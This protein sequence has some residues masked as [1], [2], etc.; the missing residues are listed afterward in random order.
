MAYGFG[1]S[2]KIFLGIGFILIAAALFVFLRAKAPVPVLNSDIRVSAPVSGALVTSPLSITG[3]ARGTWFFEA[4]FPIELFDAN[5][6]EILSADKNSVAAFVAH[7]EGEWMT[8]DFVPFSATLDFTP[9]ATDTGFLVLKKDNPSGL[10]EYD[11]SV[12]IP[13]RFR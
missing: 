13:V 4:S 7:A 2:R 1:M 8:E 5:H 6:H 3:E 12:E 11:A 10:T 9:P